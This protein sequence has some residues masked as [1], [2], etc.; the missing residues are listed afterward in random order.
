VGVSLNGERRI[1]VCIDI[2]DYHYS[3]IG[4]KSSHY[5]TERYKVQSQED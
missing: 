3:L 1:V 5:K 2:V 4:G